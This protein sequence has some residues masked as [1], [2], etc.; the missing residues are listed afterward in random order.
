MKSEMKRKLWN[1]LLAVVL[2]L[3]LAACGKSPEEKWQEQYELG[4][5]YVSE[6]NYEE[7]VLAFTAAIEIDPKSA[8][9]YLALADV[10]EAQADTES[11]QAI[12][13]QGLEITGDARFQERLDSLAEAAL[14]EEEE[15][16]AQTVTVG[17]RR[18]TE[19]TVQGE[20]VKTLDVYKDKYDEYLEL[21]QIEGGHGFGWS[22]YG[23]RF[24]EPI[25]ITLNG[26]EVTVTEVNCNG[27]YGNSEENALLDE[28]G[29]IPAG[30]YVFHGLIGENEFP[31]E[32][33]GEIAYNEEF[34]EYYLQPWGDYE[35]LID[36]L[37]PVE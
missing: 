3:G 26:E 19:I 28:N 25:S 33:S 1:L 32:T 20:I 27:F 7:A 12:L 13:E 21:Y 24:S 6:G 5:K 14:A 2:L 15:A 10:Y 11:L 22:V 35:F 8:D 30:V 36:T 23:I 18:Y 34:D 29:D 31:N 16:E 9:T 17:G 37:E 4:M